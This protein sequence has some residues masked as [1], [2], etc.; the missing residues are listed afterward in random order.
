ME[1]D[2]EKF[3]EIEFTDKM[4]SS[5]WNE[6]EELKEQIKKRKNEEEN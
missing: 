1:K 2:L 5:G 4:P 3:K 6:Y